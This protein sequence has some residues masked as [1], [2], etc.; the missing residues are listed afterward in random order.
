MLPRE[1]ETQESCPPGSLSLEHPSL[2]LD[3]SPVYTS[4]E[5]VFE[6]RQRFYVQVGIA[7]ADAVVDARE[8]TAEDR[9]GHGPARD[10]LQPGRAIQRASQFIQNMYLEISTEDGYC[11]CCCWCFWAIA[12][13]SV[14]DVDSAN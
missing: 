9:T 7:G 10:G 6:S 8:Q 12:R 13:K 1:E 2:S 5:A 4:L 14:V 11:Y 3:D